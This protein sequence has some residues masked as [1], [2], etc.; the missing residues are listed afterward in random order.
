M[1]GGVVLFTIAILVIVILNGFVNRPVNIEG[2]EQ[3][4]VLVGSHSESPVTYDVIPPAGGIHYPVWQNCGVYDQPVRNELAV[5]DLEH[6]AVWIT[7]LPDLSAD[8]VGLLRSITQQDN[9]RLLSP[10]PGLPSPI[11][12]SAWGYQL[13]LERADDPRLAQFIRQ[14]E[15]AQSAPEPGASCAGGESR[16]LS[17]LGS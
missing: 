5:H 16:T 3:I 10:Y 17:Q 15:N 2:V 13:R 14:Y 8:Q 4:P 7:Y 11:V 1:I 12:V 9:H 6:G